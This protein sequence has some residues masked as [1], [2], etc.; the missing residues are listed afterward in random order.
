MTVIALLG[1]WMKCPC[2][3]TKGDCYFWSTL[4]VASLC[5]NTCLFSLS[6]KER[7][8]SAHVYVSLEWSGSPQHL[9][10]A[11]DNTGGWGLRFAFYA[12]PNEKKEWVCTNPSLICT[13][14]IL[15]DK[16]TNSKDGHPDSWE[17][18]WLWDNSW[19]TGHLW[20]RIA[21]CAAQHKTTSL[22]KTLWH[23]FCHFYDTWLCSSH[24]WTLQMTS[25]HNSKDWIYLDKS[26][27]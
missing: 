21:T 19:S 26:I 27:L 25:Y 10:D 3:E 2:R 17:H 20:S 4:A 23:F 24:M 22:L 12:P 8:C 16:G 14:L 1:P 7:N 18:L 15:E 5:P 6:S 13:Q 9:W 11:V